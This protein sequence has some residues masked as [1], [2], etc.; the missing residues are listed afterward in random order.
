MALPNYNYDQYG[1]SF[2]F[3]GYGFNRNRWRDMSKNRRQRIRSR[4]QPQQPEQP[5]PQPATY[6]P[7]PI[8]RNPDV[9]NHPFFNPNVNYTTDPSRQ[10]SLTPGSLAYFNYATDVSPEGYYYGILNERGMGGTDARSQS[11]LGMF[12]DYAR[13]YQAAKMKNKDL[14]FP[15]YMEGQ[16]IE[17]T[18]SAQSN[19]A[20][21][22][23]D[24]R[25][26]GRD[27][28]GMRGY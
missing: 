11:A 18:L 6:T 27:R 25:F 12:R 8:G 3:R 2:N 17:G 16:D 14:W 24:R 4:W 26:Q 5:E 13:G 20:L 7:Q 22:I 19:E 21:G 23:D 15:Q 28:W 1:D 9:S 10:Q